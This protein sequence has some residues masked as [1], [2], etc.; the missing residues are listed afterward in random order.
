MA[1]IVNRARE[2]PVFWSRG[3]NRIPSRSFVSRGRDRFQRRVPTLGSIR[4]S[5][6]SRLRFFILAAAIRLSCYDLARRSP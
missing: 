1:I 2:F 3:K 4:E 6:L 5:L